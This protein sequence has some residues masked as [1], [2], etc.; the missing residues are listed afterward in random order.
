MADKDITH[1]QL[2]DGFTQ[3]L[4]TVADNMVTKKD[5]H[6]IVRDT[7][8]SIVQEEIRPQAILL[9][10]LEHDFQTVAESISNNLKVKGRV[11]DHEDRLTDLE[12]YNKIAKPTISLHSK[13]L[14]SLLG[15]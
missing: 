8:R 7:V 13:Q 10:K 15:Q 3:Q 6:D 5:V 14:K 11:D 2:L 1:Q 9:E 4:N 12:K